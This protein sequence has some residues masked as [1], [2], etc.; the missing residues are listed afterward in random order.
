TT[1]IY[2][3]HDQVEAMTMAPAS[4]FW[5]AAFCSRWIPPQTLYNHPKNKFVAGF[6]GSPAMN[7]FDGRLMTEGETL[8]FQGEGLT[9]PLPESMQQLGQRQ[10]NNPVTL[11]IRPE[12][13]HDPAYLPPDIEPVAITATVGVVEHMGNELILHCQTQ[14]GQSLSARV[15]RRSQIQRGETV[16]LSFDLGA[17]HLF[18]AATEVALA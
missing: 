1:F 17:C 14:G 9:L 5:T 8:V 4:P 10:G 13:I 18:D 15:D 16:T 3:T 11:G 6:I 7:F 12:D 2:V